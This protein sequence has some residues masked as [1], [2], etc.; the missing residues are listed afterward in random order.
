MQISRNT[1]VN[2]ITKIQRTQTKELEYLS[3]KAR[4]VVVE[5]LACVD[6]SSA[7]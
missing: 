1:E 2:V 6:T 5:G 3:V 4:D 7:L